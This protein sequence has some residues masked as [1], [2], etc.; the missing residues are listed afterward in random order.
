LPVNLLSDHLDCEAVD[1]IFQR[2]PE[3]IWKGPMTVS[4]W[5]DLLWPIPESQKASDGF[6]AGLNSHLRSPAQELIQPKLPT[7]QAFM[8]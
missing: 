1:G 3:K 6:L 5:L 8:P 4:F 7:G 2:L